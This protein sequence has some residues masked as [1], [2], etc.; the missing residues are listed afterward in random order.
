MKFIEEGDSG[1]LVRWPSS[2]DPSVAFRATGLRRRLV[3]AAPKW[4]RE[5][6]PGA[7]SLC[8]V[9][10]PLLTDFAEVQSAVVALGDTAEEPAG[11]KTVEV[12]VVYGGSEAPDMQRV[13]EHTGLSPEEVIRRHA[14]GNYRVA[15]MGF[16]PGF[17]YMVGLPPELVTPRLR[18]PRLRVLP[19][20]VGF[21]ASHTGIYPTETAGGWNIIGR[22]TT[23]IVDWRRPDPFLYQPGDRVVF[24]PVEKHTF[25]MAQAESTTFESPHQVAEIRH[26]G[27]LTTVQDLGRGGFAYQGVPLSGAMDRVAIRLANLAAG[28]RETAAAL[29]YT[30]PA[31]R[32]RFTNKA[33]FALGGADFGALLGGRPV[34]MYERVD[35]K[36]GEELV[37]DRRHRGHW[38]YLALAG[39]V[40]AKRFLGSS[41]TDTRSGIGPNLSAGARL[42]L[43][44]TPAPNGRT[45]PKDLA[46]MPG[47][48]PKVRFMPG[49]MAGSANLDGTTIILS[50]LQDRAG[51][52]SD[53]PEFE[54][55]DSSMLSEGIPPGTI[56]LPPD[57]KP[58][59]LMADRPTTGGY[60]K[61]AFFA[62]IDTRLIAQSPPG[63]RLKF[64]KVTPEEARRSIREM[65]AALTS[66]EGL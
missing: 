48:E 60:Q 6:V 55:G 40:S 42:T 18:S 47:E 17:A 58:I 13:C 15:F 21:A 62:S 7:C 38:G 43:E 45:V 61:L 20:S 66:V 64:E 14:A 3:D 25:E 12:P 32:L 37:F 24:K 63:T 34:P 28:N 4:L 44:T 46:P 53:A 35:A 50:V 49:E 19:G 36:A 39:G 41:A 16:A 27:L 29:E 30:Y 59:F 51:Y 23:K 10:D 56:Q 31:P 65:R 22:T 52:R 26:A 5:A 54:P 33:S 1:L 8:I 2:S 11:A 57:G 9:F